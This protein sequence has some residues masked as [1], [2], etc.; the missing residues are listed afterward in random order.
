MFIYQILYT[1]EVYPRK[2]FK[3]EKVYNAPVYVSI[4]PPVN[5][6]INQV[7]KAAKTLKTSGDLK[8]V[9]VVLYKD[10]ITTYEN[11]VFEIDDTCPE[12]FQKAYSADQYLI[13]LEEEL[14]KSLLTLSERTR[15]LPKIPIGTKFKIQYHTTQSAFVKLSH[16]SEA[17]NFPW[18]Q[19]T[20]KEIFFENGSVSILPITN[21]KCTCFQIYAEYF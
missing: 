13:D 1:R 16:K 20:Q 6:Y 11:Y 8:R 9:E 7:L 3:K 2:I 5:N 4:Y 18:L 19:E 12:K 21:V 10:E 14:R 17:Q 15:S